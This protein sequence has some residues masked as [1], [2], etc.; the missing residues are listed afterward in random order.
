MT[1]LTR[2]DDEAH[3]AQ[4]CECQQ[5]LSGD[6][7]HQ[8]HRNPELGKQSPVGLQVGSHGWKNKTEVFAVWPVV[9]ELAEKRQYVV[10]S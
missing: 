7:L 10:Q 8:G 1:V 5:K 3:V 9:L 2:V 4:I 6:L